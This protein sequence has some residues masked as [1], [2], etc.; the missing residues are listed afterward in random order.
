MTPDQENHIKTFT[1]KRDTL[2]LEVGL[3]QT[4]KESLLFDNRNLSESNNELR[5]KNDEMIANATNVAF[6]HSEELA[7]LREEKIALIA[8][9]D[10][11]KTKRELMMKDL[12]EK[13]NTLIT[14]GVLIKSIQT[15]TQDTTDH[16]RKVSND[17]NLYTSKVHSA[18]I[19]IENE[20]NRVKSFT[21]ELGG[22][23]DAER[24]ANYE[25]SRE[26]DNREIAVIN[27]EKMVEL[28]YK[29]AIK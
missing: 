22:V 10:T 16:I 23:I 9:I 1:E 8:D 20:A 29:Q 3:L 14:L 2:A 12:D 4:E 17:I 5:K 18:S 19:S 6:Q 15:A 28:K 27:R 11:L 7:R 21:D 26:I 13:N 24:K 25:K